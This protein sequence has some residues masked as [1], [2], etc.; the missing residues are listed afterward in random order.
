M[1]VIPAVF[2][3]F[4]LLA[5]PPEVKASKGTIFGQKLNEKNAVSADALS[6]T[7]TEP[8]MIKELVVLGKVS[9]V[10][11][12][13][14][15]WVRMETKEGSMLVKMKDHAFLVPLALKGKKVAVEGTAAFTETSVET[16]RHYAEDAGKPEDEIAKITEPKKEIVF[17]A[18][19]L[20]V[21]D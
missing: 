9:E 12:V 16:L 18:T 11:T 20:K 6:Q 13:Q 8:G 14:G 21:L 5:Q 7:L 17:T 2:F 19:G 4:I 15:C 10:C 1:I 3:A